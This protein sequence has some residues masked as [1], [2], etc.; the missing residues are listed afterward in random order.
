MHYANKVKT[1][2]EQ[3]ADEAE[4]KFQETKNKILG[5]ATIHDERT[6]QVKK[7]LRS[8]D[9]VVTE[10]EGMEKYNTKLSSMTLKSIARLAVRVGY[11]EI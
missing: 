5:G 10:C 11:E 1:E 7:L 6:D 3:K 8:L 4:R 2:L 9:Q